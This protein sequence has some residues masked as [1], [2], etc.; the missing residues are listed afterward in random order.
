MLRCRNVEIETGGHFLQCL[1]GGAA[2]LPS[3][4]RYWCQKTLLTQL[5]ME[6]PAALLPLGVKGVH[7]VAEEGFSSCGCDFWYLL[8]YSVVSTTLSPKVL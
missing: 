3:W 2:L 1:L 4:G 8:L 7:G 6:H 5:G